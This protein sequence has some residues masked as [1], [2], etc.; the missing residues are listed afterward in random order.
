MRSK[1]I[2]GR[3]GCSKESLRGNT[4]CHGNNSEMSRVCFCSVFQS[5]GWLFGGGGR[6]WEKIPEVKWKNAAHREEKEGTDNG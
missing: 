3:H 5:L 2:A 6:Q 1:V 4:G